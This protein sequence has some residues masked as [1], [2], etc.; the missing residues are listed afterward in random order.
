MS[1]LP[2]AP[3]PFA[4]YDAFLDVVRG[5]CATPS[6]RARLRRA[7]AAATRPES[8]SGRRGTGDALHLLRGLAA[9]RMHPERK[10][11]Y[12]LAAGIFACHPTS[13]GSAEP[14]P[15]RYA[16]GNLGAALGRAAHDGCVTSGR[17]DKTMRLL[18]RKSLAGLRLALPRVVRQL[19]PQLSGLDL[20]VVLSDLNGWPF[21]A[22]AISRRWW[23]S[24]AIAFPTV[25]QE[26]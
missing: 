8:V 4:G 20:A 26:N 24:Y 7:V 14:A 22:G 11:N 17:A 16:Q 13:T 3:D 18:T 19:D 12:L 1:E 6:A 2:P 9:E 10:A 5:H 21:R 23:E 15:A 25:A